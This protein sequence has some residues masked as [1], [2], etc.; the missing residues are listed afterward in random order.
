MGYDVH[1]VLTA[2]W[3]QAES[4]P[5]TKVAVDRL[6]A[7]DRSLS[8]STTDYVDIKEIDGHVVRYFAITWKG[9]SAFWWLRSEILCKDPSEAQIF[10][11]LGMAWALG[12][13]VLGDD[14]ERYERGKTIF[15]K[16]KLVVLR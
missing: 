7:S 16:P 14:G 3:T 11:L 4:Q 12:G 9:V 8:W 6:I 1:V 10:K 5:I 2:D 13:R 15:G